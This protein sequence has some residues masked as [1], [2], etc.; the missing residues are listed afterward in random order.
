VPAGEDRIR[1]GLERLARVGDGEGAFDVV[2]SKKARRRV[3][4]RVQV[5]G[6]VAVVAI[7]TTSGTYGLL[8][9]FDVGEH[10]RP[11][12]RL[13][14][15]GEIAFVARRDGHAQIY[16][17]RADGTHVRRLTDDPWNDTH[18]SWSPD[19]SK[20]AF[21]SDRDGAYEI[22]V[23]NADGTDARR[24]TQ[25]QA[26]AP[27]WSPDGTRI[28]FSANPPR[29]GSQE[30]TGLFVMDA[31]GSNVRR[32]TPS[33][34]N[35]HGGQPVRSE[36]APTWSSDGRSI[37]F[38]VSVPV[39]C[40]PSGQFCLAFVASQIYV[41]NPDG[42]G[43]R[44][45]TTMT[46]E[47]STPSWSPDGRQIALTVTIPSRARSPRIGVAVIGADGGEPRLLT[48]PGPVR[49]S[50]PQWS[51]D[52]SRI[53]FVSNREGND[54]IFVM[55]ANGTGARRLTQDLS[56]DGQP[57]WQPV[58]A[59]PSESPSLSP[60][61]SGSPTP[62]GEFPSAS[63]TGQ[64]P[65]LGHSCTSSSVT[66]DFDGDGALD[67]AV[68]H[69]AGET[70]VSD[71][72]PCPSPSAGFV[73]PEGWVIDVAWGSGAAGSWLLPECPSACAAYA[74]HDVDGDGAAEVAVLVERG[75][76]TDFVDFFALLPSEA[77]PVLFGVA[78]PGNDQHPGGEPLEAA[79]GGS[80]VHQDFITCQ[81]DEAG[82]QLLATSA[83]LSADGTMWTLTESLFDFDPSVPA[84]G[85]PRMAPA[86]A[87]GA[88][89]VSTQP[90]DPNGAPPS[91]T[92]DPCF[93]PG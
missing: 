93:E 31:D 69:A 68:V 76:S 86:F 21:A 51:P 55:N 17:M 6:L 4:R 40:P 57:A 34:A 74:T 84:S 56:N 25:L 88:T 7:G 12:A 70:L 1:E 36:S 16:V 32:L 81:A 24:L 90:A 83:L 2:A 45:L 11:M 19:G 80:V 28:A 50:Q 78:P 13:S 79:T 47:A 52:G 87:V 35:G 44:R 10:V 82:P 26:D 9:V 60:S 75:A 22:Y 77:G 15:N 71:P 65:D 66:A 92:G 33:V 46:D 89:S 37:A 62:P 53:V 54:D 72:I 14:G 30:D 5:V 29:G 61:P 63:P 48:A 73:P 18:P 91:V 3:V 8:K 20:L 85:D 23:M 58:R 41:T 39:P 38:A 43:N 64:G 27:A 67:T 49:N 42:H 59:E